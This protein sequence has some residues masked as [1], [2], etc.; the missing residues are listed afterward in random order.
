MSLCI[1][2]RLEGNFLNEN[3]QD[4]V[5][6]VHT[7]FS[8]Y[9]EHSDLLNHLKIVLLISYAKCQDFVFHR[10]RCAS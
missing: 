8:L 10:V 3:V 4:L 6:L 5:L 2:A 7:R 9:Q 1:K